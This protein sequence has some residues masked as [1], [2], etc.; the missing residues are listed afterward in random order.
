MFRL[1]LEFDLDS[2]AWVTDCTLEY[3]LAQKRGVYLMRL[4]A[5]S[6][7]RGRWIEWDG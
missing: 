2:F 1:T 4:T 3:A 7:T 5:P 6:G